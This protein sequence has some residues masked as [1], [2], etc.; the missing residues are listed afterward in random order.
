MC[1]TAVSF[2][3]VHRRFAGIFSIQARIIRLLSLPIAKI[4]RKKVK[5]YIERLVHHAPSTFAV[6][7]VSIYR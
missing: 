6:Y 7:S 4:P 2:I 1:V 5:I 3:F